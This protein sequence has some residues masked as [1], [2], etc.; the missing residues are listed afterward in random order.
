MHQIELHLAALYRK[1]YLETKRQMLLSAP[2]GDAILIIFFSFKAIS[3][4]HMYIH[5]KHYGYIH[6]LDQ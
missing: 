6:V 5:V 3:V 4:T 1:C 2:N